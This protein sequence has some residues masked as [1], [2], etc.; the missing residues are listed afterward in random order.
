MIKP[1]KNIQPQVAPSA[2]I[3]ETAVVI[4][5]VVIGADTSVW[6]MCSVRGDV[7]RIRIGARTNIQDGSVLHGVHEHEGGVPGGF[8]VTIGDEVTIGHLCV[9]HGCTIEHRSL[10]GM[11]S[12]IL[13]GAVLREGV[14][15]G[16]G[17]LV[18]EGKVLEGGHLWIGRPARK[19]RPLTEK[20]KA[21][22]RYS[23]THYVD[24]KDDYLNHLDQH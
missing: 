5:D 2:Y 24:L 21:W 23:A 3:D 13:D 22:F 18:T 7:N 19:I 15:L 4:G 9:I 8:S 1:Y 11:G 12:T 6:P 14:F 20:E 16:A 10:V 17:S